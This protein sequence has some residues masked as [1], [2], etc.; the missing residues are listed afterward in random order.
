MRGSS[1]DKRS[2]SNA[3]YGVLDS[4]RFLAAS[5][6][7]FYHFENHFQP[8]LAAPTSYLDQFQHF[9]DFFFVLSGFVIMHVYGDRVAT[10]RSYGR[11]M[12][13]RIARLYPLHVAMVAVACLVGLAALGLHLRVRDPSFFDFSLVPANLLLIQAWGVTNHAGLNEP[14]WSLSAEMFVYLLFPLLAALLKRVG[15]AATLA[16]AA[17]FAVATEL[18]RAR[19]GIGP[20]DTATYDFGIFRALPCFLA[21]MATCT[22]V[23]SRPARPVSWLGPHMLA[24]AIVVLMLL[25]APAYATIVLFPILVGWTAQAERGGRPTFL[26]TP[27]FVL[28]GDASYAIYIT[29]TVFQIASVSFVRKLG[30]TT[31]FDLVCVAIGFYVV[32]VIFGLASYRWFETPMRKWLDGSRSAA[33]A[34]VRLASS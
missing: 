27:T 18:C 9:V 4:Y 8:F 11:F 21:G 3:R 24:L 29:H 31:P 13:K 2:G 34:G 7:V 17:A 32:I 22:I 16:A 15:P 20:S 5:G 14:S 1:L 33:R 25:K 26:S 28:L 30:L 12:R 10:W 23:E 19:L 6:V